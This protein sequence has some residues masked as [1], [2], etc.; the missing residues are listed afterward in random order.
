MIFHIDTNTTSQ[1]ANLDKYESNRDCYTTDLHNIYCDWG[2]F[3]RKL[4]LQLRAHR[5]M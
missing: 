2:T 3:V 4:Q 5:K 1:W